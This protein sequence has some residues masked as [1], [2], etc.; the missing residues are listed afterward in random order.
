MIVVRL[1]ISS[2][3]IGAARLWPILDRN[4]SIALSMA[5]D[6]VASA[7]RQTTLFRDRSG[8][9]RG[10]ILPADPTGSFSMGNAAIEIGA[11][12]ESTT[13]APAV[14]DG[15]VPHEIR[16][17]AGRKALR[18][19]GANG[20]VFA[21]VVRH[22]GT[23]PRPFMDHALDS[24]APKFGAIFGDAIEESFAEAFL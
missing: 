18:F 20:F 3:E 12:A 4:I 7:A 9:L 1:N 24:E 22:P 11:G 13:Y 5:G 21:K 10:S 8:K 6:L 16:P 23:Q 19:A 15:S 14:H 17:R 2:L